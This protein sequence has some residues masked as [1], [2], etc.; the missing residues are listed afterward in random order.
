VSAR[1]LALLLATPPLAGCRKAEPEAAP[2]VEVTAALAD[3]AP[4]PTPAPR[5]PDP[6]ALAELVAAAPGPPASSVALTLVGT[7]T[8]LATGTSSQSS[9]SLGATPPRVVPRPPLSSPALERAARAQLYWPL[10][11]A[12]RLPS[13][14]LPPAD[15]VVLEFEIQADGSVYPGSVA[16]SADDERYRSVAECVERVFSAS[17]FRGPFEGRGSYT[18]VRIGWPSID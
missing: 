15:S 14:E 18:S 1:V 11:Q 16:A 7:D 2:S 3:A 17:G 6:A 13:G 12:C 4:T 9:P 8:G 10:S 5:R